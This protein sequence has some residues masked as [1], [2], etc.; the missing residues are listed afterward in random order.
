MKA[1]PKTTVINGDNIMAFI[2]KHY[3]QNV[4]K[5][6]SGLYRQKRVVVKMKFENIE[7]RGSISAIEFKS[8]KF[9]DC[10]FVGV[11]GFFCYFR[12]CKFKKCNLRNSRF[13]HFEFDW[14]LLEFSECF[15][16]NVELDE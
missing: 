10:Q 5:P 3:P 13:S 14:D 11:F 7:F 16:R 8:C 9:I 6:S 12:N 4:G 1:K 2:K 15:F